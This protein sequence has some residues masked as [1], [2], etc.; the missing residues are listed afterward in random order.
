MDSVWTLLDHLTANLRAQLPWVAGLA[1]L[2]TIL[3][4]FQ[5]QACTPS[6][7]WWKSRDLLTDAQYFFLMPIIGPYLK[8]VSLVLIVAA[9]RGVMSETQVDDYISKGQG[10]ISQLPFWAQIS[11]YV[12]GTD[13]LLYWT[14]RTFHKAVLWPFHAVHHSSLD[15]DWTTTYRSHPINQMLGSGLVSAIM[16]VA[17]VPPAIMIALVPF[18]IVSAAFVHANLNWSLGPMK[19]IVATPVFHRWHHTGP[20]E[21]GECNFASTFSIWDYLFGTFYM[22]KGQLP[23][24]FGVDDPSFPHDWLGQMI[25][26]FKLFMDRVSSPAAPAATTPAIDPVNPPG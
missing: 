21:G 14:H 13:L 26:P 18:D 16:I 17:G 23:Q 25:V 12:I 4:L 1:V 24:D 7:Q 5:S 6:R 10:P 19:Y 11:F 20:G 9:M 2:F 8:I 22:P 15:V 3:S